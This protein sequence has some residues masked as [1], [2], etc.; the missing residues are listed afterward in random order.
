[1]STLYIN[2]P[3]SVLLG[4]GGMGSDLSLNGKNTHEHV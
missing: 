4:V 1:M 3:L 2:I